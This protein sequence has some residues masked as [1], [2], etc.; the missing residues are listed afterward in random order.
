[1]LFHRIGEVTTAELSELVQVERYPFLRAANL[2]THQHLVHMN[3]QLVAAGDFSIRR[4]ESGI[5]VNLR[6]APITVILR[7]IRIMVLRHQEFLIQ[8]LGWHEFKR[9]IVPDELDE[10]RARR[11]VLSM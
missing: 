4:V 7:E 2:G 9:R 1:M 6:R 3:D 5:E 8:K 11:R 10:M